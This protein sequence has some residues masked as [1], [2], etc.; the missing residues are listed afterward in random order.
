MLETGNALEC[1]LYKREWSICLNLC[2]SVGPGP[3]PVQWQGLGKEMEHMAVGIPAW[4]RMWI[5]RG[6]RCW[7]CQEKKKQKTL[8]QLI[9]L[10]CFEVVID[11]E[12]AR[13][14]K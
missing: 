9:L 12:V 1:R 13:T 4:N 8:R 6:P 3:I 14:E 7:Y 2:R 10:L 5:L 11:V